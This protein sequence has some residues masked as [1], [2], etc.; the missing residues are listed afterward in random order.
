MQFPVQIEAKYEVHTACARVRSGLDD[1]RWLLN[2][3]L[4]Q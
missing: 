1:C 3:W 4:Q 2:E